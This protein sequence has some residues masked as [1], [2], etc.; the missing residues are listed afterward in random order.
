MATLKEYD[1]RMRKL[2]NVMKLTR[3][4]KMVAAGKFRK[5]QLAVRRAGE[6]AEALERIAARAAA[7]AETRVSTQPLAAAREHVRK[8]LIVVFGAERGLCGGFAS[9]LV[10]VVAERRAAC[11]GVGAESEVWVV[12]KRSHS[13]LRQR[14]IPARLLSVAKPVLAESVQTVASECGALFLNGAIDEAYV[15]FAAGTG[16]GSFRPLCE[17]ILPEEFRTHE[18]N[19]QAFEWRCEPDTDALLGSLL[20]R[21]LAV[22]MAM[23]ALRSAEAEEEAR[24]VAMDG[25]SRNAEK[26]FAETLLMRN[27]SRQNRITMELLDI[28]GGAEALKT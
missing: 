8:C 19:D 5:A 2:R 10:P 14:G 28:M 15:V 1:L 17:R 12:G 26:L 11:A 21:L 6:Y 7:I 23:A 4:M 9:S 22:R 16:G 25:A 20:E 27:R 18:S 13:V 24:M 3:T